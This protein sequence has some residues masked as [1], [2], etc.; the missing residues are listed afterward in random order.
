MKHMLRALSEAGATDVRY[1]DAEFSITIGEDGYCAYLSN[2]FADCRDADEA[3]RRDIIRNH[4]ATALNRRVIPTSFESV[5][6]NLLPI[7]R[8]PAYAGLFRLKLLLHG[9]A[10]EDKEIPSR[11]LADE[12]SVGLACDSE[13]SITYVN[14]GML[15]DWGV[16]LD[17]GLRVAKDNLRDRTDPKGWLP[18]S[19]GVF[20]ASWNDSYDCSRML[21]TEY[22]HRL[23]LEGD[24]VLFAPNRERVWI[25]GSSNLAGL[26][27]VLRA[28]KESH[29]KE[30]HP[31]SPNLY[32]LRDQ[33]WALYVPNDHALR[34]L[35]LS[36][37]RD[38]EAL[39]YQQQKEDLDTLHEKTQTDIFVASYAMF[40]RQL[41]SQPDKAR[42]SVCV[43]TRGVESLLP[44]TENIVFLVDPE[45]TD[46][47]SVRWES[48]INVVGHLMTKH[49]DLLP[50]RYHVKTFPD[51]TQIAELRQLGAKQSDDL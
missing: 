7:I 45:T 12:L 24:P 14:V 23:P 20:F 4:V 36:I 38:R 6:S 49:P 17:E 34:Q 39:D 21:L 22:I 9:K 32:R 1:N 25:T 29:F 2:A 43:W 44:Q 26:D 50:V 16:S 31:M 28:G 48:A 18:H 42:F 47:V 8:D 13:W 41:K 10:D 15:R 35:L 46:K 40:E 27:Y 11:P 3:T 33:D 37:H 5:R 30:G 19:P 51:D